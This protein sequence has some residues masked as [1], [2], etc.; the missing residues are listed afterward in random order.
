MLVAQPDPVHRKTNLL[1]LELIVWIGLISKKHGLLGKYC[2][3]LL[4]RYYHIGEC[5]IVHIVPLANSI[6]VTKPSPVRSVN[7][8]Q[9]RTPFECKAQ[10]Q[11]YAYENGTPRETLMH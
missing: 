11:A 5:S 3:C 1:L 10:F 7:I 9:M 6:S 8:Q 2:L 4:H